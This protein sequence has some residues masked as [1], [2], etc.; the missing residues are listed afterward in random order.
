M[1]NPAPF[2]GSPEAEHYLH[3][4][5]RLEGKEAGLQLGLRF[6]VMNRASE[7]TD[8][9]EGTHFW[10]CWD[11]CG[12]WAGTR[13]AIAGR[14]FWITEAAL[15][16]LHGKTLTILKRYGGPRKPGKVQHLL[17]PV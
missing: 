3:R 4:R 9:Y 5:P 7:V 16:A 13:L 6:V 1:T 11:D 17:V 2:S 8:N 15:S 10:V 12:V 14:E